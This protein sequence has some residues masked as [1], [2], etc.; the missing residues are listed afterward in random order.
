MF[1]Y[2]VPILQYRGGRH[3]NKIQ[4][5]QY[6]NISAGR[7]TT[8]R[9]CSTKRQQNGQC[10]I[11]TITIIICIYTSG[12]GENCR[13]TPY[14]YN[15]RLRSGLDNEERPLSIVYDLFTSR[16]RPAIVP[17]SV[18]VFV[19]VRISYIGTSCSTAWLPLQYV[20]IRRKF[21]IRGAHRF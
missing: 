2:Y 9:S 1:Y 16:R 3:L 15:A 4:S 20:Y 7:R 8:R 18:R 6:A 19:C 11:I 14:Y 10:L 17:R 5:I 21:C 13:G 12:D